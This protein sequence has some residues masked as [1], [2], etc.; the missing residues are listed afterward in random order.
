MGAAGIE[1]ATSGVISRLRLKAPS[2]ALCLDAPAVEQLTEQRARL[3][4]MEAGI[5]AF[6]SNEVVLL[7]Q[8]FMQKSRMFSFDVGTYRTVK[9]QGAQGEQVR[10]AWE[11]LQQT[12]E[13]LRDLFTR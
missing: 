2:L 5:T 7:T 4:E 13:E 1:P 11:R 6:G 8:E 3:T 10:Q 12:R 9:D